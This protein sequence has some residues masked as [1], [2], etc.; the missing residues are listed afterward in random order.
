M[1]TSLILLTVSVVGTPHVVQSRPKPL[2]FR[3]PCASEIPCRALRLQKPLP[4]LAPPKPLAGPCASETPCQALRLRNPLLG[5]ASRNPLLGLA[6]L[7]PPVSESS[8]KRS[9]V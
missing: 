7:E 3:N 2:R 9:V 8:T 6:P 4:G 1:Y 5:L